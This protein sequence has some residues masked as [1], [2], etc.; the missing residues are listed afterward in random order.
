[1]RQ[2]EA[3]LAEL[4]DDGG[5]GPTMDLIALDRARRDVARWE[6]VAARFP[7]VGEYALAAPPGSAAARLATASPRR[8]G[9][10]LLR[11]L[12][13]ARTEEEAVAALRALLEAPQAEAAGP[14]TE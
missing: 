3:R 1:M 2:A 12:R 6:Q 9:D 13:T 8:L 4:L 5:T 7:L 11:A 14:R 10:A